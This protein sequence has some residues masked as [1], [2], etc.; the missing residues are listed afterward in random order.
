[1]PFVDSSLNRLGSNLTDGGLRISPRGNQGRSILIIGTAGDGPVNVPIRISDI[2]GM[3]RVT[4]TFGAVNRGDLLHTAIECQNATAAS[5]DIRLLRISDGKVASLSLKEVLASGTTANEESYN[6]S[7]V[8]TS[9]FL[10]TLVLESLYPS[11]IYNQI[12]LRVEPGDGIDRLAA[13]YIVIYNPKTEVE[14]WFS[15]DYNDFSSDVDV[16]TV[17]ELA[18]AINADSNLNTIMRATVKTLT[19]DYI[20]KLSDPGH[21]GTYSTGVTVDSNGYY[22][23]NL[24]TR[25]PVYVTSGPEA[26]GISDVTVTGGA[27]NVPTT[28]NLIKEFISLYELREKLET[29][30]IKGLSTFELTETPI[31]GSAV[32]STQTII[33]Y[34]SRPETTEYATPQI[35]LHY[36][37]VVIGTI[38]SQSTFVYTFSSPICPDDSIKQKYT[39]GGSSMVATNNLHARSVLSGDFSTVV[40]K[41]TRNNITSP[42]PS[43]YYSL[44][45]APSTDIVTVTFAGP[46]SALSGYLIPGSILSA[47]YDSVVEDLTDEAGS[48]NAV[49]NAGDFH[50]YFVAGKQ[51]T[52]GAAMPADASFR[53]R[54]KHNMEEGSDFVVS[55]SSTSNYRNVIRFTSL[56]NQP[57]LSGTTNQNPSYVGFNYTYSPQWIN[58][59]TVMSLTG[60]TDGAYPTADKKYELLEDAFEALVDYP[61]SV[62]AL[63]G[64]YIDATKTMYGPDDGR[65]ITVNAGYHTLFNTFLESLT[66]TTSET[67][68][69][70]SVAPPTGN[71]PTEVSSWVDRLTKP[72]SSDPTRG[73]NFLP[74]FGSKYMTV[75]AMVPVFSNES[76]VVPYVGTGE[77]L[78]SGLLA[79][80]PINTSPSAKAVS[81]LSGLA[82][83]LSGGVNGQLDKLTSARLVTLRLNQNGVPVVTAGVTFAPTGSDYSREFT[84]SMVFQVMAIIRNICEPFLGEGNSIEI[85]NAMSTA[86]NSALQGLVEMKPSALQAFDFE[87][88]S[89]PEDQVQGVLFLDLTLVPV[90]ELREIRVTVKLRASL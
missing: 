22:T 90:F 31:K 21:A 59:P 8:P 7:A 16:H 50:L 34:I 10:D 6:Y 89:T 87:V 60:G 28:G 24:A 82:F 77:G 49:L 48:R 64:S 52:F 80:L 67:I 62:I 84:R 55:S 79:N 33:K 23:I 71:T 17:D 74:A 57:Q 54:Y 47:D 40:L 9:Q 38:E 11:Q 14:S 1:M 2:G 58:V 68:G 83:T 4:D 15:Y 3:R 37:D 46:T 65:P 30:P 19:A 63:A 27:A 86:I 35:V 61:V 72:L 26:S 20:M 75:V 45:Y 73:G 12:T 39:G 76:A 88:Y 78:Y 18:D 32:L 42:I 5:K 51:V 70:M 44:A 36:R 66:G 43:G 13:Q 53:Y 85:R 41:T 29:I 25:T 69:I 81:G 56:T